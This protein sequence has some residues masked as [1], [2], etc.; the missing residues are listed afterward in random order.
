MVRT[1]RPREF[2]PEQALDAAVGLFWERGFDATTLAQLRAAMGIS[3]ASFYATFSSKSELF[4]AVLERYCSTFGRVT[5]DLAEPGLE[6]RTVVERTLRAS[7]DMQTDASHPRGCL[8]VVC[9]VTCSQANEQVCALLTQRRGTVRDNLVDCV[10]RAVASGELPPST[11]PVALASMYNGFLL[12]I[13]VQARDGV[14]RGELH[15]AVDHVM[16]LWDLLAVA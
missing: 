14:T 5:D 10:R 15:A 13:S 11:E 7:I 3:S 16:Q 4:V 8:T 9:G 2:D 6:P 1:G 12:G